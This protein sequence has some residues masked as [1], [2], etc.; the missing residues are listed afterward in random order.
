[1]SVKA[2]EKYQ[3]N[4]SSPSPQYPYGSL[5]QDT[6]LGMGDGTPLDV[7][8]GNDFEAFKQTAFSRSGLV[9][10]GNTDTVTNSEMFNAMQDSTTRSLWERSAAESGY[11]LVAGSFEE[12]GTLVN[13]NDVLWSKKLNKIFSGPAGAVAA[14]TY[15]T[16]GGFV[17]TSGALLRTDLASNDGA[18]M[19]GTLVGRALEDRLSDT[20]K[21]I[22]YKTIGRTYP[23]A[24]AACI[25]YAKS[26]QAT[27]KAVKISFENCDSFITTGVGF[28]L[29]FPVIWDQCKT[30]I[31][32]DGAVPTLLKCS[33]N[34]V[35][36]RDFSLRG[37]G[38][39]DNTRLLWMS[40]APNFRIQNGDA[41]NGKEGWWCDGGSYGG[42]IDGLTVNNNNSRG[43]YCDAVT[44][45]EHSWRD[46]YVGLSAAYI[47]DS[48]VGIEM[49]SSAV[50]DSGG[51]HW[52]N[53]L[54][55]NNTAAGAQA[56]KGVYLNGSNFRGIT[57]I[58]WVGGGADGFI[59]ANGKIGVS[60][61][62]WAQVKCVNVWNSNC[63]IDSADSPQWIGGNCA[64]GFT[65]KGTI[66]DPVFIAPRCAEAVDGAYLLDPAL[67]IT[68]FIRESGTI[69][70]PNHRQPY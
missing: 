30:R 57:P 60:I 62:N 25:A 4:A 54:V 12:G 49:Y 40:G 26:V 13:A 50:T 11:N 5:R 27:G 48:T 66:K 63:E 42:F 45:A 34:G 68:G 8:W 24:I 41:S 23:E 46:V 67:T 1:M 64:T 44:S 2:W 52:Y 59:K 32:G 47:P 29:D 70:P 3:P 33:A 21:V 51:Y 39:S 9:P 19:I 20:I 10:S 6:A 38:A 69:A 28:V 65:L 17:D 55:V 61:R 15:P 14:G 56:G 36:L 31:T 16:S 7:E 58:H 35:W 18:S 22:D 53:V 37:V 43:I